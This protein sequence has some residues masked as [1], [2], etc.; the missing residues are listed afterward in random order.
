MLDV[1]KVMFGENITDFIGNKL[2]GLDEDGELTRCFRPSG[3]P[4]LWIAV[5]TTHQPRLHA[6]HLVR[7]PKICFSTFD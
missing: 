4:G 3:H 5:G 2:F 7:F 6:K 1:V